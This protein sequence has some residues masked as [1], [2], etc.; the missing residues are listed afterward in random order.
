MIRGRYD[1]VFVLYKSPFGAIVREGQKNVQGL[2][3]D[4]S[5]K[6]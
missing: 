3:Y 6:S 5:Q 2:N 4:I 1:F